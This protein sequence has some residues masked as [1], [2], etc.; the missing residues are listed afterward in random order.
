MQAVGFREFVRRRVG[1]L[2][3]E[4]WVRNCGDG[5][6]EVVAEGAGDALETLLADLRRGPAAARVEDVDASREPATGEFGGFTIARG[7]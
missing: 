1:A 4:G 7:G 6:V 5:S 3:L 2:G